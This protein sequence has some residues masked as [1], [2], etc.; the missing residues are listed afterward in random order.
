MKWIK[1]FTVIGPVTMILFSLGYTVV[2]QYMGF[3]PS[4]AIFIVLIVLAG[5][6]SN[7][8][9]AVVTGTW[10]LVFISFL[11]NWAINP[12]SIQRVIGIAGLI[13]VIYLIYHQPI[14]NGAAHK[15]MTAIRLI[16]QLRDVL[17][18]E[19]MLDRNKVETALELT[20]RIRHDLGNLGTVW[21]GW[22][23]LKSEIDKASDRLHHHEE[24]R[25]K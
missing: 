6:F 13:G 10:V 3:Q 22:M 11:D 1:N 15:M 9:G 25:Q 2:L 7:V 16:D 17:E 5:Y 18:K 19:T 8:V 20:G 21:W 24:N 4:A 23:Q 12:T 14:L